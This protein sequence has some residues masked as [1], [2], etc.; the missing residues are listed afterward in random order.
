MDFPGHLSI[1]ELLELDSQRLMSL[2]KKRP[3]E[4]RIG[5][6]NY[7]KSKAPTNWQLESQSRNK[8]QTPTYRKVLCPQ[9]S[10][11]ALATQLQILSVRD[12]MPVGSERMLR[13]P[14]LKLIYRLPSI[15][16]QNPQLLL[17]RDRWKRR[18][19]KK[20]GQKMKAKSQIGLNRAPNGKDSI[21]WMMILKKFQKNSKNTAISS[22]DWT[23]SW[24]KQRLRST[25]TT[26]NGAIGSTSTC[27]GC[28]KKPKLYRFHPVKQI[29]IPL[30]PKALKWTTPGRSSTMALW[31]R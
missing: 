8:A 27:T 21:K 12:P 17:N 30:M 28:L 22:S 15:I 9:V 2:P 25:P 5:L 1:V 13:M 11:W 31:H 16:T 20:A 6:Q 3:K 26:P 19:L 18:S 24:L 4:K 29:W 10:Q 23:K 7:A 14:H